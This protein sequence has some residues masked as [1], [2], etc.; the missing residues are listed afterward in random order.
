MTQVE[1]KALQTPL[2]ALAIVV[3]AIAALAYFADLELKK[4]R[5]QFQ[6]QQAQLRDARTRLQKSGDEKELIVRYV[7]AYQQ[8]QRAGFAGDE[9]RINWLDGLRIANQQNDLFGVDYQI[10]AQKAY[11]HAQELNPGA[12]QLRQSPMRLR[13]QL[14]HEEDLMRFFTT[15]AREGVGIFT[16]DQCSMKRLDLSGAVR[17]QPNLQVD[18]ELSWI[19]AKPGNPEKKP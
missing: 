1:I 10:E 14:L 4:A 9:N 6:A 11:L 18:C 17:Y 12:I 2:T 16:I 8:L 5:A 13:F 3:L 7:G 19:T 15:L